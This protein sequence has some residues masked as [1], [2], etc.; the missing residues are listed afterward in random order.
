M[1]GV[2][3]GGLKGVV[4]GPFIQAHII[5]KRGTSQ[6]RLQTKR[7][8]QDCISCRVMAVMI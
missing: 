6:E 3:G 5:F 2:C 1:L 4:G 8:F 7:I